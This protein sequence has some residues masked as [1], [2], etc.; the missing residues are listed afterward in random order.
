MSKDVNNVRNNGPELVDPLPLEGLPE[1]VSV[2]DALDA[3]DAG[4]GSD[5]PKLF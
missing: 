5:Q 3:V 4:A 1:G 2:D